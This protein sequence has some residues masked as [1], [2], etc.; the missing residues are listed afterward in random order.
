ME[1]D[2][3][4]NDQICEIL[5][6]WVSGKTCSTEST[7]V[8]D[9]KNRKVTTDVR[10]SRG[11]FAE[12]TDD[13]VYIKDLTGAYIDPTNHE[14]TDTNVL[15]I[16]CIE[17]G[18]SGTTPSIDSMQNGVYL[19]NAWDCG[20]YYDEVEDADAITAAQEAG[21]RTDPYRTDTAST[22]S[23]YNYMNNVRQSDVP[24]N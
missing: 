2:M 23:N 15:R 17:E 11:K 6:M 1:A 5:T 16:A 19:S 21:Y 9:G 13:D 14:F 7:W 4:L 8:E 22:A 12:M 20:L 18:P 24:H 10:L 3:M